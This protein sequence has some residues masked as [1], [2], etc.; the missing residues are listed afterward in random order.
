MG[1]AHS[2]NF[3]TYWA[4]ICMCFLLPVK[5]LWCRRAVDLVPKASG[6]PALW[7]CAWSFAPVWRQS[8]TVLHFFKLCLRNK[9]P[10]MGNNVPVLLLSCPRFW[11]DTIE[12]PKCINL[13]VK[14]L[15]P[16]WPNSDKLSVLLKKSPLLSK[17][18]ARMEE[19]RKEGKKE[20]HWHPF[21]TTG[22]IFCSIKGSG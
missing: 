7:F 13:S 12:S 3:T 4:T 10:F 6:A 22:E 1:G 21:A 18:E 5:P 17:K 20:T 8:L 14:W 2:F 9:K 11:G 15:L 19:R 16:S